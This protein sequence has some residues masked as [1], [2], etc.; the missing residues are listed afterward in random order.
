VDTA[1]LR[2]RLKSSKSD[3]WLSVACAVFLGLG[4]IATAAS[5]YGNAHVQPKVSFAKSDW[6]VSFN[7]TSGC[8]LDSAA[9]KEC[10]ASPESDLWTS[11][12]KRDS[13]AFLRR[14]T[15]EA[16]SAFW[17]G[18]KIPA[19]Q[20]KQAEKKQA[21]TL[22][23]PRV[24]G[25]VQVWVDGVYLKTHDFSQQRSPLMITLPKARLAS[26]QD[27]AIALGVFPYPHQPVPERNSE[28]KEGF[29]T[30]LDS[31]DLTRSSVFFTSSQHL[32]AVALFLL[33]GIFLWSVSSTGRTRDYAV[34]TQLS[35]LVA[36]TTLLSVDL[37][38]QVFSVNR[39]ESIFFSLLV[40]EAVLVARFAWTIVRGAR[41]TSLIEI[42]VLGS[43]LLI[44]NIFDMYRW[45]ESTG[46]NLMAAW[47]LP[48]TYFVSAGF[49]AFRLRKMRYSS[50]MRVRF[51]MVACVSLLLTSLA[52]FL[53][54]RHQSGF[55]VIWSRWLNL[56]VLVG[57]VRVFTKSHQT[58]SSL[59]EMAPRS[60]YH[61]LSPLPEKVEGW[62]LQFDVQPF[63]RDRQVMSTVV[64]H[65]WTISRL[66]DGEVIR[67]DESSLVV[68]FELDNPKVSNAL[69][70]MA[71][72]V[73]DLER[74][75]PI[76]I[77]IKT[78]LK[79]HAA[80]LKGALKP[81]F[82]VGESGAYSIPA[83]IDVDGTL[84]R[85][86]EM[87]AEQAAAD[88]SLIVLKADEADKFA[89]VSIRAVKRAG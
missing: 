85:L 88:E 21:T 41:T 20:L 40:L 74:R 66:N 5:I 16:G 70:E 42:A 6:H 35:L 82:N 80:L 24:N 83:W 39:Y 52:Y 77:P 65:L 23:L 72:C 54:S 67:A 37:S 71:K 15:S 28:T 10:P 27:L 29:Y 12:L 73:E 26:G 2:Q 32:I 55:H 22:V 38:F 34:G 44:P 78:H 68:L 19:D 69:D 9:K 33:I 48:I 64:S 86:R 3:S 49:V 76:V 47:V 56:I 50:K 36:L 60:K 84:A 53:E 25:T 14:F 87:I 1:E 46:V 63:S 61:S 17:M 75:L 7:I 59:I 57:L 13:G 89:N 79:F 45:I 8:G 31:D 62:I 30:S 11:D 81:S 58:K 18:L 43:C 4:L 51:L